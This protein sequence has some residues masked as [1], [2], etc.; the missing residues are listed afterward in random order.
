MK[1]SDREKKIALT[2]FIIILLI[3]IISIL[4]TNKN[5]LTAMAVVKIIEYTGNPIAMLIAGV[6]L[7]FGIILLY[8]YL[9]MRSW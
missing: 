8:I 9:F 4:G 5:N 2:I 7:V 6:S 1:K 3:G